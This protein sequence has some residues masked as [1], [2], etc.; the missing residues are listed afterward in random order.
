MDESKVML[1]AQPYFSILY[2]PVKYDQYDGFIKFV[3]A[4]LRL[5]CKRYGNI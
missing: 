1:E 3:N 4:S 2:L 5:V